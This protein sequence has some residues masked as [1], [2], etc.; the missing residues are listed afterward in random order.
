MY[1]SACIKKTLLTEDE[2]KARV[3]ELGRL[4]TERLPGEKPLM[5]GILKGAAPFFSDLIRNIDLPMTID[6]MAAS[7][8]GGST[9]SSGNIRITKD[10]TESA[11]GRCVIIVE[12]IVDTGNTLS[13]LKKELESRGAA[14]VMIAALLDKPSRRKPGVTLDVDFRGFT[15]DDEFVVG[16]GLD[17][18][19]DYR[20]LPYI[21]VLKEECYKN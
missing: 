10:L 21:G 11:A 17:Y 18:A 15:I 3:S 7:S 9:T 8:Y 19:E 2:I 5:V 14:K 16:Y 4:I 6:F 1:E 12:D 13:C 20:N